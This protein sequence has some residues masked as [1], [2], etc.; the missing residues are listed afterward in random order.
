[1]G[2]RYEDAGAGTVIRLENDDEIDALFADL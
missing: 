2:Q 1:M